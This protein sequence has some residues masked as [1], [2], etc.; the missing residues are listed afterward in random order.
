MRG[1]SHTGAVDR[2]QLASFYLFSH[3]PQPESILI[4]SPAPS[5]LQEFAPRTEGAT[6]ALYDFSQEMAGALTHQSSTHAEDL[7]L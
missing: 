4:N 7:K 3:P 6:V 5:S 1:L 2:Q